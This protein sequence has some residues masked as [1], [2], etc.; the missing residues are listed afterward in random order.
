M[1]RGQP[2][3]SFERGEDMVQE[4]KGCCTNR[5]LAQKCLWGQGHRHTMVVKVSKWRG[6]KT[7][8]KVDSVRS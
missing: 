1:L 4:G 5:E 2:E 7:R 3:Q 8:L 6:Q